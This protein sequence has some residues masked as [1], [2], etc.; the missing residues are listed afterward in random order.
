MRGMAGNAIVLMWWLAALTAEFAMVDAIKILLRDE[1]DFR[2]LAC[3]ENMLK[4]R[5]DRSKS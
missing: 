3:H 4:Q 2:Q 5:S 1:G